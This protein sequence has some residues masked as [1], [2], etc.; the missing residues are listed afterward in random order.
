[1]MHLT[2]TLFFGA[3]HYLDSS[4]SNRIRTMGFDYKL[5]VSV[6]G[7]VNKET[8]IVVNIV[9]IDSMI[10][11]VLQNIDGKLL[12]KEVPFFRET[13]PS[14]E[15]LLIYF[16]KELEVMF[17]DAEL[18]RI[19]IQ[20][21][22]FTYGEIRGGEK[23]NVYVTKLFHFSTA[24]RLHSNYLNQ[25]ENIELFGKC[26]NLYGHGHNYKLEVT[27]KGRPNPETGVVTHYKHF[28]DTVNEHVVNLFDH[29]HINTDLE[30]FHNVN[31]TS[32][33]VLYVI[34]D[35]LKDKIADLHKIGIWETEKNYFE[36]FGH[37]HV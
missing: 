19:K 12:D 35:L 14:L 29:K 9:H 34:W 37:D 4:P 16:W 10:Q 5:D 27:V 2:R 22:P 26:N 21:T 24:H 23:M 17:T 30:L 1:M 7:K 3:V 15:N 25:E 28:E 36:Y 20:Q 18:D 33:M 6:K 11:D 13:K 31:P 32:E 8:G